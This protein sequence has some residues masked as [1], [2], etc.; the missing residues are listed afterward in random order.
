MKVLKFGG[1]SLGAA[2]RIRR[3][4][5]I[6]Q[7]EEGM[8]VLVLSA[9]GGT[10]DELEA[11]RMDLRNGE[12]GKARER[13]D[14]LEAW[15]RHLIRSLFGESEGEEEA[16]KL[17]EAHTEHL[18]ERTHTM[19]TVHEERELL[20]QG[21]LLSTALIRLFLE[22][23]GRPV[24]HLSAL[25]VVRVDEEREPDRSFIAE[26]LQ[27][28]LQREGREELLVTE[29]YVCRDPFGNVDNLKRGGS[30]LTASLIAASLGADELIIWTDIDGVQNNDP[31]VVQEA[32]P[33]RRMSFDEA[34]ELSYFGAKVLHPSSIRPAKE[35]GIPVRLKNS[36][37][38]DAE[39]TLVRD[40]D[41]DRVAIRAIAAKDG[42]TAVRVRSGRMLMAYGFLKK[43]FEIFELYRTPID[44][45][46]TSEVAVSLTID[47]PSRLEE[48][49][50]DLREFGTVE[51]DPDQS[52]ICIVGDMVYER[53]GTARR[54]FNA[55]G[56][57]P[58]RMIAYGGSRNNLSLLVDRERKEEALKAL[59]K[60]VFDKEEGDVA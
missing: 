29:G 24:D 10:T 12:R 17:L 11:V 19:T 20:A 50:A 6:V 33:I 38:P 57:I 8:V 2:D 21:E 52:I 59:H 42:I 18:R 37:A 35:A 23:V 3:M 45:I 46:T 36:F 48:I 58:V 1:T 4:A 26:R 30:D 25:D 31:R 60:G 55:L 14:D 56:D 7:E 39:G 34:A 54:I 13:I 9:I 32:E 51:V 41:A 44:M 27:N 15:F 43:V 49:R 28:E 53:T 40:D 47:D 22:R 5:S 16:I